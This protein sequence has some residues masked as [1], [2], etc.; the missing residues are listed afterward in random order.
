MG[1]K[2]YRDQKLAYEAANAPAPAAAPPAAA[3]SLTSPVVETSQ[4]ERPGR[5]H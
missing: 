3:P 1:W 2:S 4:E 5:L